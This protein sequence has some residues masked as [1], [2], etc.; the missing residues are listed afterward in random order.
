MQKL[1]NDC[2]TKKKGV[3][4]RK[5]QADFAKKLKY[6]LKYDTISLCEEEIVETIKSLPFNQDQIKFEDLYKELEKWHSYFQ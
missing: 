6:K 1:F 4:L 2:D 3:L 5:N